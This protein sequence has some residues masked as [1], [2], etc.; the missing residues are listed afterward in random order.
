MKSV[1]ERNHELSHS[2]M[3]ANIYCRHD[4]VTAE[5]NTLWTHGERLLPA[6]A[7]NGGSDDGDV[8]LVLLLLHHE[9]CQSFGVGVCVG[10]VTDE[11]RCDV[12]HDTIIHPP[13]DMQ[14]ISYD[15]LKKEGKIWKVSRCIFMPADELE[16]N[17]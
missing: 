7:H 8:E 4:V 16:V 10:P 17:L 15:E 12:T 3:L 11:P 5:E 13:A 14:K 1:G 2:N 6:G 9:L